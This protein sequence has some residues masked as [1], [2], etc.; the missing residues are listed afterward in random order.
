MT[1]ATIDPASSSPRDPL[2]ATAAVCFLLWI[3]AGYWTVA[4][5]SITAALA[6]AA[7]IAHWLARPAPRWDRSR[8]DFG[9]AAWAV[10]LLLSAW[11]A[12]DRGASLARLGKAAFP[13]MVGLAA[14]HARDA[15]VG[16]RA[17][18]VLLVSVGLSAAFGIALYLAHGHFFPARARG[19][20][21]HYITFAGQ[22]MIGASVGFAVALRGGEKRWRVLGLASALVSSA[23]LALTYTRSS[24]IGLTGGLVLM[25]ALVRPLGVVAL[26][27]AGTLATVFGPA[28]FRT[29]LL[30]SF[31]LGNQWNSQR[32]Y[33]WDAGL[34]MFRDH[35]VT[36]V[37]LQDLHALYERYKA[38]GAFEPAGHLHS[39]PVQVAATMGTVGLLALIALYGTLAWTVGRGL[40]ARVARGGLGGAVALG[41]AAA[42]LGFALA[43][44][45]EWNLGDEELLHP[46]YALIGLAWAARHWREEGES[47]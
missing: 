1:A 3:A 28:S 29:R 18:A 39:V 37:G 12:V 27:A 33:M 9:A 26:A 42:F 19:A 34:R 46:L 7:A 36:G 16:R 21:G 44:L 43:G 32:Q 30:S 35:P 38:P 13:F 23:A 20:V 2:S 22:L 10:A 25:L 47:S 41:A 8:A 24:W 4:P 11:F 17:L 45:F 6:L 5:M 40:R 15:R 14:W 31:D